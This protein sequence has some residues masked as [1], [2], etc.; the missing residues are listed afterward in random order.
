L[1]SIQTRKEVLMKPSKFMAIGCDLGQIRDYTAVSVVHP[2]FADSKHKEEDIFILKDL[3]RFPLKMSYKK[4]IRHIAK[5]VHTFKDPEAKLVIELNNVGH[6]AYDDLRDLKAEPYG[7]HTTSGYTARRDE[8]KYNIHYVPKRDL[9]LPVRKLV[10]D[11]RMKYDP[12]LQYAETFVNELR[13]MEYDTSPT[14]YEK[15]E[16]RQGE[17][18]DLVMSVCVAV[19]RTK[20]FCGRPSGNQ[21]PEPLDMNDPRP[22]RPPSTPPFKLPSDY[23][24]FGTFEF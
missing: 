17:H 24:G 6:Y 22:F 11:G 5:G 21:D 14:G 16:A 2:I 3:Y 9:I 4:M 13:A 23:E 1:T 18:D 12:Q 20:F 8:V 10:E 19:W 7:V 15:F